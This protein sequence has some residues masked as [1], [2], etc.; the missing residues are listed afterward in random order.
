MQVLIVDDEPGIRKATG[1]ALESMGH[2]VG[3]AAS[4]D[5]ALEQLKQDH[6]DVVMLDLRLGDEDGLDVLERI[7][8]QVENV[9][10]VVFAA[11]SSVETAVEAMR[12]GAVDYLQKPFTPEQL[13]QR[14]LWLEK[15]RRLKKRVEELEQ[16]IDQDQPDLLHHSEDPAM[17]SLFE[18]AGKA[19]RS[20]AGILI[21]GESGTGKTVLARYV[22][23]NSPRSAHPFLTV[24][25]PCLSKELLESELFGHVKGAF[26]G[27]TSD[28]WGRVTAGEGGTLF[29]DE[30][31]EMPLEIQPKLLRLLQE[32]EY[33]RIGEN[34]TRK[35]NVRVIAATNRDLKQAVANGTFRE[36]L[37]YRLNVVTLQVPSLRERPSDVMPLA[38]RYIKFYGAQGGKPSIRFTEAAEKAIRS[39]SWPG[40]LREL[41]N[42]VERAVILSD[43]LEVDAGDLP[44]E[45]TGAHPAQENLPMVGSP[46]PLAELEKAHILRVVEQTPTLEEAASIL[47]ID[48]ATLYRKRKRW[49][50]ELRQTWH[51]EHPSSR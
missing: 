3:F 37:Y 36:D 50:D 47:G 35:A 25:C 8:A 5:V 48:P 18:I 14:L 43:G 49:R 22:H 7:K 4:G 29:L 10:V 32:R 27:A 38:E 34:K 39:Y 20:D 30:I 2:E 33:E 24:S 31:G 9:E 45:V 26:T 28:K 6:Y 1:A 44:A 21:L 51:A 46:L 13:E 11:H 19:A 40:N 16:R 23:Q 41:R 42:A 12:R 17:Q 15:T